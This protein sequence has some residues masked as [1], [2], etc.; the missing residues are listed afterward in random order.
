MPAARM[1]VDGRVTRLVVGGI[2]RCMVG[3]VEVE[4][5]IVVG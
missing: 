4:V 1:D 2:G 5:E 3:V